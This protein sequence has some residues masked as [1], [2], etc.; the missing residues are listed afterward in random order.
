MLKGV[1]A[2][3]KQLVD[4]KVS[5]EKLAITKA[6]RSDYKNPEQIAHKVLS[7]RMGDRDPGNRPRPGDRINAQLNENNETVQIL[8]YAYFKNV[9][10]PGKIT[11]KL[12][13][14]PFESP[15]WIVKLGEVVNNQYQYSIITTP[16]GISLWV[17]ARDVENFM[18]LYNKEVISFLHQYGYKYTTVTQ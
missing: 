7:N 15:Y 1:N 3:L 11:I 13:G 4:G 5:M 10:E 18:K 17:L 9:S 8:G 2:S 16:S 12:D 14:V 6:L